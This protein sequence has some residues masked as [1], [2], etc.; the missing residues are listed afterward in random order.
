MSNELTDVRCSCGDEYPADSYD[1]GFIAGSGM[2]Q[3]CDAALTP[4]DICTCPSGDGSLRHPCPAHIGPFDKL[5]GSPVHN[6]SEPDLPPLDEHLA[7]VFETGMALSES[8]EQAGGDERDFQ[9]E[10][11]QEVPSPVSQE[12]DRHLISLL[13][14][15]E[16]LPGHQEEAADEIERLRDWNDHLNNTV[17]PNILNPTFLMLMKGGERLL[18]LCTKDGKFIGV[19]LNDMKDVFDWM[20]THARI[21]PDHAALAQPSPPPHPASELDFSRPLETE[22]GDPVKWICA[23]VIEYKS[24]RVCVAKDTGLVYSSP[25]IGL[26]IRNVMPE[27]AE[28]ERP[29]GPTEDELEAAGLGYPLHKEEA[30]KLWYSGFRSEVITVL[31]AWEAIGHDIGMNPDKGELLDSLRYMLEKC[32][33][34]DAALARVAELESKLAEL[35]KQEPVAL[36]NRGIHAFWVKWTEAAAGLYGPGIKLY[37]HPVAQAQHSV[38]EGVTIERDVAGTIHIKVGDFDFI[39]LQYQRPY[40]DNASTWKL[41]ERIASL[42]AAAPGKEVPQAWLDV[43]AERRRQVEAEGWT[44]EH[45]D[46]YCAAE[47]PRAAAAYILNGANDEAPAIW[48]FSAKWWKPRDARAN[49]MRAGALILAEIERLDRAAAAGKEVGHE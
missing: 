46:L 12:Y 38:P 43:Q 3:N 9:A 27:Q 48:P 20:V 2:C 8:V 26:K 15:G 41:A 18:D 14:K 36:A 5:V 45:D 37:A 11:A 10:G 7:Q 24:A 21:A 23:D 13:R 6:E 33:A 42:L 47:L 44:P 17:L 39:Q 1:A 25:Y 30:V 28:A 29:E 34:H 16:A 22:N 32:E 35:E 49:Y 4:K 40:T 19:S 31:E